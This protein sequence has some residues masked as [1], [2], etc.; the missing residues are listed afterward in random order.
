ME[1]KMLKK[2]LVLLALLFTTSLY[3]ANAIYKVQANAN[4]DKSATKLTQTLEDQNLYII[5]KAHISSTLKRMQGK[6]GKEYNKRKYDTVTS[7]IFCNPFYAN[8]VLN[9]DPNMM[10]LCPL[11]IMLMEKDGKT[12]ALFVLPSA[13]SKGSPAHKV[14][15]EIEAKVKKALKSAGFR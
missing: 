13:L 11:K 10:A 5:S 14:L 2:T 9:L 8:D 4:Y 1:F 6:L 3:S 7:L 12:T 15:K